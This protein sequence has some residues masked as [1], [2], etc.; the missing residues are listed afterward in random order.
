MKKLIL[1]SS[2]FLLFGCQQLQHGQMRA[3]KIDFI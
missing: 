1:A 2:L 3:S